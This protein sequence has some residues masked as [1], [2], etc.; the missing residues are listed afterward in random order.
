L[1]HILSLIV[2]DGAANDVHGSILDI[3]AA[4]L[5]NWAA[6]LISAS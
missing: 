3:D 5:P 4:I 2:V 6:I 1:P